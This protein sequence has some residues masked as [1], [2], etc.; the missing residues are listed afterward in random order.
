MKNN[1]LFINL[2]N[3]EQAKKDLVI[4]KKENPKKL[5]G[6]TSENDDLNRKVLEK[7]NFDF[8]L[9]MQ[10]KR[11]DFSKQ[12][13]SGLNQVMAKIAK[14]NKILIGICLNEI[15]NSKSIEKSKII[16]RVM[17]NIE[18]CKKYKILMNFFTTYDIDKYSLKSLGLILG[19]PTWMTKQLN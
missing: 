19:M 1:F 2:K 15:I 13:N 18:L 14:K 7:L 4:L 17:Q 6:F 5:I 10:S 12:R 8:Y 16:A 11:K 9:P 3:F